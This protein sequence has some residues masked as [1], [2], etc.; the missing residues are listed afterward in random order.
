LNPHATYSYP[1]IYVVG[2][3]LVEL[4]AADLMGEI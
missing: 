4:L 3:A 1:K 2:I